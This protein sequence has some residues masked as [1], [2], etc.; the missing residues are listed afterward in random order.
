[1]P[2]YL[3]ATTTTTTTTSDSPQTPRESVNAELA[4]VNEND[5]LMVMYKMGRRD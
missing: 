1:M 5:I 2:F 4:T 3:A